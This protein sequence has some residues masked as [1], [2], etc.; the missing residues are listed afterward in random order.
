M[1]IK[2]LRSFISVAENKSFSA[3]ARALH[4]VQPAVSRHIAQL[5]ASLGVTLF[6]RN[7]R[8]VVIT[9]AGKQLLRDGQMLLTQIETAMLNAKRANKGEIGSLKIAHMPSACL[10]FM[11]GLVNQYISHFP[12]VQVNLYEMTVTQQLEAFKEGR[13]DVGFSRPVPASLESDFISHHIYHDK[14]VVVVGEQHPLAGRKTVKLAELQQENFILFNRE[15][16]VG[17]FDDTIGL[18]NDAGFSPNIISQPRHMQT[19]LTEIAS[20]LGI[21]LGP[22]C[23]R[24]QHSAGC[25]FLDIEQVEKVI[26]LQLHIKRQSHDATV[27][28]FVDIVLAS[29][30]EIEA[31]MGG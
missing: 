17:L 27:K 13:I 21:G 23:I 24:K 4:T 3:A 20:G 2:T 14:L 31:S 1:D 18:C 7:S 25:L 28:S 19:L 22:Y 11:A 30:P 26:P 9:S 12:G 8:E 6:N 5:E 29:R 16:A 10:P 15:E